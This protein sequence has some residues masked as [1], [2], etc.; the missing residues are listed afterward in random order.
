VSGN[1]DDIKEQFDDRPKNSVNNQ[2]LFWCSVLHVFT[3]LLYCS[4]LF[5]DVR[6][7]FINHFELNLL[8]EFY[9]CYVNNY[10]YFLLELLSD[11]RYCGGSPIAVQA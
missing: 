9:R 10:R 11:R 4:T 1:V 5:K 7:P 3:R 2:V 8:Q 6:H